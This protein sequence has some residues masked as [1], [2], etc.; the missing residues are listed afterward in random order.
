MYGRALGAAPVEPTFLKSTNNCSIGMR[1]PLFVTFWKVFVSGGSAPP[2]RL[3]NSKFPA[4]D[5]NALRAEYL[6]PARTKRPR[7]G[8][9]A[10]PAGIILLA[11]VLS[12]LKKR[13]GCSP[14]CPYNFVPSE[15]L[16]LHA[17]KLD[18]AQ[19]RRWA[20]EIDFSHPAPPQRPHA[21]VRRWQCSQIGELWQ[22]DGGSLQPHRFRHL[23]DRL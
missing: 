17:F 21:P 22:S 12:L 14:P 20:L 1:L 6:K 7:F 5:S 16:R 15:A 9:L 11:P 8:S 18:P 10:V 2:K 3:T 19:V 4:A 13:L 23:R